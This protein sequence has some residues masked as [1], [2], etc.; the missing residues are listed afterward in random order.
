MSA[1]AARNAGQHA[2]GRRGLER[3]TAGDRGPGPAWRCS[4]VGAAGRLAAAERDA[5]R[6]AAGRR[7]EAAVGGRIRR[8]WSTHLGERLRLAAACC[9]RCWPASSLL[10]APLRGCW[11][12][13][14]LSDLAWTCAGRRASA[15]LP[16]GAAVLLAIGA[17]SRVRQPA[18]ALRRSAHVQR[19]RLAA[20]VLRP[21]LLSRT[22]T[23]IC[24]T[25][26]WSTSRSRPRAIS[27]GSS[28]C[29]RWWPGCCWCRRRTRWRG[30]CTAGARGLSGRGARRR[31][32]VPGRVLDQR[33]RLHAA[34]A[35]L[36]RACSCLA[37][38]GGAARQSER[39]AAGHAGRRAGRVRLADDVLR[40]GG[41]GGLAGARAGVAHSCRA[42]HASANWR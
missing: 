7:G 35:V 19:V 10:R 21:E 12:S 4:A 37:D 11:S 18:D 39:A 14:A 2:L 31:L 23:T 38:R 33:A 29:R 6:A 41:R 36:R 25:R 16:V 24:S 27:R 22:R 40:R 28:D 9:W 34:G 5:G 8:T 32:V 17:A 26:C 1:V 20:A 13:A 42:T 15:W 3:A 30:C